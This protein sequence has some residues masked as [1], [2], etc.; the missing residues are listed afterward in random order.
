MKKIIIWVLIIL[1]LAVWGGWYFLLNKNKDTNV[2]QWTN[3]TPVANIDEESKKVL[4]DAEIQTKIR[5][6]NTALKPNYLKIT[7]YKEADSLLTY[8][9][10]VTFYRIK[11]D[12]D[13]TEDTKADYDVYINKWSISEADYKSKW[14]IYKENL[15]RIMKDVYYKSYWYDRLVSSGMIWYI[16]Q[17]WNNSYV[18][19]ELWDYIKNTFAKETTDVKFLWT[20]EV[21]K[22]YFN[23]QPIFFDKEPSEMLS[24]LTKFEKEFKNKKFSELTPVLIKIYFSDINLKK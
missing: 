6:L 10:D 14:T 9:D 7:D 16:E 2:Q 22:D 13:I 24:I 21:L 11:I 23:Y 8:K 20:I 17:D 15:E 3:V 1:I 5:F 12:Y 18:M 4:L 19:Y